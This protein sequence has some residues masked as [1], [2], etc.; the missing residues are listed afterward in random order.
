MDTPPL[1]AVNFR[2]LSLQISWRKNG[3][4]VMKKTLLAALIG[5][6]VTALAWPA[7]AFVAEVATSV[8]ADAIDSDERLDHAVQSAVTDMLEA[9]A[10]RLSVVQLRKVQL[11]G[12][13]IYLLFLVADADGEELLKV[14]TRAQPTD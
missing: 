2:G 10:V 5:L 14:F 11:V 1:L 9:I 13:R 8:A 7:D 3:A 12:D 6:G 4:I